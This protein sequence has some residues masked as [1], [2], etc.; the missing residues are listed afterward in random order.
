MHDNIYFI[1]SENCQILSSHITFLTSRWMIQTDISNSLMKSLHRRLIW[2]LVGW[3]LDLHMVREK[4]QN[5]LHL[6]AATCCR[7]TGVKIFRFKPELFLCLPL[8]YFIYFQSI[9]GCLWTI[10]YAF[11][12]FFIMCRFLVW[13]FY[14]HGVLALLRTEL[15]GL[16][17]P[18][19]I[20]GASQVRYTCMYVI[21]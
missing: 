4:R 17:H 21:I 1:F 10:L 19:Y 7:F 13:K 2:L 18:L 3:P 8:C 16:N 14:S 15:S 6:C 9:L 12:V 5:W 20:V 11:S